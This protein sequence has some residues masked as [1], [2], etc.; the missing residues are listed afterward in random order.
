MHEVQI[1]VTGN[2]TADVRRSQ[3]KD[4][5]PTANF[6]V[7]STPRR[8]NRSTGEFE[9]GTTSFWP[10]AVFGPQAEHVAQAV[11]KGTRVIVTGAVAERTWDDNGAKRS[12]MEITA[13]EVALSLLF[14][15]IS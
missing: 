10:V 14:K 9:D 6:T 1:T 4:G 15:V 13:N 2:T 7:A 12:R 8:L 5:T 11:A 3:T